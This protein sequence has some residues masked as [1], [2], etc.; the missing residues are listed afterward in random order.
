M[1]PATSFFQ[2]LPDTLSC[3]RDVL[4]EAAFAEAKRR[5]AAMTHREMVDY[6]ANQVQHALAARGAS[7]AECR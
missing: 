5:G 7:N 4:G 1:I 6:A 3:V 2:E